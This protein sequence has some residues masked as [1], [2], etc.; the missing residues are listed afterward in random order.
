MNKSILYNYFF[1]NIILFLAKKLDINKHASKKVDTNKY[2][3]IKWTMIIQ[4]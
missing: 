2:A 1:K 4:N 3:S